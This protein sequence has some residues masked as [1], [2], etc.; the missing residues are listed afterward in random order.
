MNL[1]RYCVTEWNRAFGDGDREA[2]NLLLHDEFLLIEP[3]GT[4]YP[5]IYRGAEGWWQF[6]EKFSGTWSDVEIADHRIFLGDSP[7]ECAIMMSLTGKSRATGERFQTSLIENWRFRDG[8][9][10]EMHPHYCDTYYLRRI[11]GQL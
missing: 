3:E 1:A 7:D 2:M 10:L 5:G 4:P 6:W 9:I 8:K 11:T